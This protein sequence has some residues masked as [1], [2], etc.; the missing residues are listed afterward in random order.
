MRTAQRPPT[1]AELTE[2]LAGILS[3]AGVGSVREVRR[4]PS[5]Y[6][7]SFPLEELDAELADGSRLRIGFKQLDRHGLDEQAGLAKP[8]F[9]DDPGREPA[10]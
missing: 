9:L 1:D 3:E 4:R 10:V 8:G 6:R 7:T 5:E 2:T